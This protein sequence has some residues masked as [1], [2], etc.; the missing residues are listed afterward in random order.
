[1][2]VGEFF[3]TPLVLLLVP[4]YCHDEF[5]IKFNFFDVP[6][7]KIALSKTLGYGI[8]AG[9]SIIKIPQIIKVIQASSVEGL[10]LLSFLLELVALTATASYSIAKEF[11]FSSCGES[12][13]MSIQ[14]VL[15]ICLYFYYTNKA[16]LVLLFPVLYGGI[17]YVLVSGLT[18]MAV[19]VQLVS[20]Q[21]VF[22]GVSRLLQ[23][24]ANFRNGHTGQLSFIM[25]LLLFLGAMARIFTTIQETGDKVMLVTFLVSTVLNGTL[26]FQVLF[27]WNVKP[28]SKK[29]QA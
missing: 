4:K 26:V 14:T 28:D 5:F 19:L 10:S 22:L 8:V 27:Y 17:F 24:V 1:M 2:A 29:K 15:L 25:V 3:F 9:S 18:P 12:F 7:L 21:I 11:P 20:L 23:I 13:F 16:L 6:C